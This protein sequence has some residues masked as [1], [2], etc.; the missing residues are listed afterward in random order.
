MNIRG[1]SMRME[2]SMMKN[3]FEIFRPY[4]TFLREKLRGSE[5]RSEKGSYAPPGLPA[6][7]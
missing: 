2:W 5:L 4:G 7:Y 3:T 6:L 1:F